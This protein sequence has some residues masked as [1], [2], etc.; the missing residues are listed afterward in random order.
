[1]LTVIQKFARKVLRLGG[2]TSQDLIER[3]LEALDVLCAEPH[4][5]IIEV[6]RH[7]RYR[8]VE[9]YIDMEVCEPS[10]RA[11]LDDPRVRKEWWLSSPIDENQ[12]FFT[13][14]IMQQLLNGLYFIHA[15]D[16][17]HRDLTP[18]NGNFG[19]AHEKMIND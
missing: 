13:V 14:A 12:M 16:Q 10:L 15:N 6:I 17:V 5:N 8:F 7:A 1:M 18:Q 4:E 9:Y 11:W 3:E 19:S 2:R